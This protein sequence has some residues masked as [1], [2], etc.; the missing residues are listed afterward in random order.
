MKLRFT[1]NLSHSWRNSRRSSFQ[2]RL[3]FESYGNV[4]CVQHDVWQLKKDDILRRERIWITESWAVSTKNF[5]K[6]YLL[7]LQSCLQADVFQLLWFNLIIFHL[8]TFPTF[9]FFIVIFI[10]FLWSFFERNFSSFLPYV[11]WTLIEHVLE[12]QLMFVLCT[13][14]IDV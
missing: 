11:A 4:F 12:I 14:I 3:I 10:V 13:T 5:F 6:V 2:C 1:R 8:L 9:H 7:D